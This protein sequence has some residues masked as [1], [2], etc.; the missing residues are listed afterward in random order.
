MS[1]IHLGA[2]TPQRFHLA[3]L[4]SDTSSDDLLNTGSRAC[5]LYVALQPLLFT[6]KKQKLRSHHSCPD[7]T[8]R[9]ASSSPQACLTSVTDSCDCKLVPV[10]DR[11]ASMGDQENMSKVTSLVPTGHIDASG[12]QC[13]RQCGSASAGSN[14]CASGLNHGR[15]P[16]SI[17][18]HKAELNTKWLQSSCPFA[19]SLSLE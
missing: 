1:D 9:S 15:E 6:D 8:G 17:C 12:H 14:G 11:Q 13:C 2:G 19:V 18:E 5:V 10:L 3:A 16:A 4:S 7:T